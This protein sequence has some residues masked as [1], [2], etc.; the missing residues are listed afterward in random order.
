MHY[1][2]RE[3]MWIWIPCQGKKDSPLF[4]F[5]VLRYFV[6]WSA[7]E[8]GCSVH[9]ISMIGLVFYHIF[10]YFLLHRFIVFFLSFRSSDIIFVLKLSGVTIL[11]QSVLFFVAQPVQVIPKTA[12]SRQKLSQLIVAFSMLS[13]LL[14]LSL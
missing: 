14:H 2:S 6:C 4:M 10:N 5:S 3:G 12:I 8:H 11:P 9:S 7:G 1:K 13:I